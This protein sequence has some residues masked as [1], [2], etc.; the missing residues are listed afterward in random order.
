[1]FYE[2]FSIFRFVLDNANHRVWQHFGVEP[3]R[4]INLPANYHSSAHQHSHTDANCDF[5]P[6]PTATEQLTHQE[7]LER[8]Y[9][10]LVPKNEKCVQFT[11]SISLPDYTQDNTTYASLQVRATDPKNAIWKKVGLGPPQDVKEREVLL[12]P[13]VCRDA[14]DNIIKPFWL[15]L[16]GKDFGKDG[17]D[18]NVYYTHKGGK[19]F[20]VVPAQEILDNVQ[21]GDRIEI[22]VVIKPGQ[23][24]FKKLGSNWEGA[25]N[26]LTRISIL[27]VRYDKQ[28][29]DIVNLLA[30]GGSEIPD[31]FII[32][33]E[34]IDL[35]S[36]NN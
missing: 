2:T 34:R 35:Y 28:Y 21:E 4:H 23:G 26:E 15:I 33:P 31:D 17:S 13:V 32:I 16:G 7:Q 5:S 22:S 3:C 29:S 6:S 10:V 11:D 8:D 1:M 30:Q 20:Q 9:G 27:M 24:N 18:L 25:T 14:N 36:R 19:D 12:L